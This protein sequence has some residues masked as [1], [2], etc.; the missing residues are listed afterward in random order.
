MSGKSTTRFFT[1][2][3]LL[4]YAVLFVSC[5]STPKLDPFQTRIFEGTFDDVWL[6]T[7]KALNDYPLKVSNKDAG[8]IQ[9]EIVNGPYNDL[10]FTYPEAIEVPDRYR[11][12][13]RFNFGKLEG[14]DTKPLI[15]V[16]VIKDLERF[17]DFYT[18]WT[19]YSSDGLEE[20]II[21]YRIE[22]ILRMEK[23]LSKAQ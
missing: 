1:A 9:S 5:T 12:S 14:D 2:V 17:Q 7:L 23:L 11:Y 20:K 15:R 16:R 21:L 18:G 6:A 13:L 22:H 4:F 8:K 19:P 3:A 10:V